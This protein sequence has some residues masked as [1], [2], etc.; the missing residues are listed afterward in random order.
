MSSG[1]DQARERAASPSSSSSGSSASGDE[2]AAGSAREEGPTDTLRSV[3]V[4]SAP[5]RAV[6]SDEG[7]EGETGGDSSSSSEAEEE[8]ADGPTRGKSYLQS[9]RA[10]KPKK[11]VYA[12]PKSKQR[13]A[14]KFH[15]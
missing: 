4:V 3:Q 1:E 12:K 8:T 7:E 14:Q 2:K 13:I 11:K 15:G 9:I 6:T 10:R 5:P